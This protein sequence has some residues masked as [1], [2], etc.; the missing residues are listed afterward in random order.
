MAGYTKLFSDI[1][2]SSIWYES[3]E[4]CKVWITLL[5]L[6]DS[7]GFVRGSDGWLAAKSR[8]SLGKVVLALNKFQQ[9]D[10][11][12]RTP[13]NDGRRI[14]V[15]EHGWMILNY[16]LFRDKLTAKDP[17]RT[18]YQREWMRNKRAFNKS[19]ANSCQHLSTVSTGVNPA[20]ASPSASVVASEGLS[21]TKRI[22]LERE[23]D[24]LLAEQKRI[25]GNAAADAMGKRYYRQ[26]DKMRL[27]YIKDRLP[28][29]DHALKIEL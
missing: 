5:A 14:K 1:V 12:S 27:D 19:D 20:S 4:T 7:D 15:V 29:L 22:A 18:A 8:V 26:E 16:P 10:I 9:P 2:D 11:S 25:R 6:A 28:K 24:R 21:D 3:S 13:D 23:R 17:H